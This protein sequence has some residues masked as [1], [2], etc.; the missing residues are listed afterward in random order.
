M[1]SAVGLLFTWLLC[2]PNGVVSEAI[3]P[4]VAAPGSSAIAAV[5]AAH[6]YS[7]KHRQSLL[8]AGQKRR[9]GA[10]VYYVAE[11]L[12][13]LK[14][15]TYHQQEAA[16][17]RYELEGERLQAA[18]AE[19]ETPVE[20]QLL[21]MTVQKT[22]ESKMEETSAFKSMY[23]MYYTMKEAF[24]G[25]STAPSCEYL[26][27]GEHA[28]CEVAGKTKM[29]SCKCRPCFTG[30]GFDCK[31]STCSPAKR[32]SAMPMYLGLKPDG[33][34][35]GMYD[36]AVAAFQQVRLVVAFRDQKQGGR[37]FLMLGTTGKEEIKWG[38]LQPF[39]G[40]V[41]AVE[42]Q[43]VALPTG[44]I[45]IHFRD[46]HED[47]AGFLVGGRVD[48]ADPFKAI[49][50]TPTAYARGQNEPS[51]LVTLASSRVVCLYAHPAAGKE[52]AFGGAL[53][54]QVSKGGTLSILGKYHFANHEV[55][56]VT[57]LALRPNSFVVAFRDPPTVD[58]HSTAP[59]RELSVV[60][61]A[62]E[63]NELFLDPHP[64][65][66]EPEKKGM[67]PRS[68]AL[69]SENLFSY[70]YQSLSERKS[71]MA[72]VRVDPDSHRMEVVG[73]PRDIGDG[74]TAFLHSISLPYLSL[75]P[76]T[77]TYFQH[78]RESSVA[79]SCRISPK[80]L[81]LQ[82][83]KVA[84]SDTQAGSAGAARLGDGRL[85]FVFSNK[86]KDPF[87]QMLGPPG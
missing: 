69:V 8:R 59:S 10:D 63:D 35:P 12:D 38:Q 72:I 4:A 70:S 14:V 76:H 48:E 30:D 22:E 20:R 55:S 50:L 1:A 24:G 62:M 81:I 52:P 26:S 60:W 41:V 61:M 13:K 77:F 15:A 54:L 45:V 56:Y 80:G 74:D 44:R 25:A 18:M 11:A 64:I 19:V 73:G 84:W 17:K 2:L 32:F 87:Y 66:I 68:L 79:K 78:P 27:C 51:Q 37:G 40:D 33:T 67:G 3:T 39:S 16:L 34:P 6:A 31:P 36:V 47:G 21:E 53:F 9:A 57:A 43:V 82:C 85:V 83:E 29:A 71:R 75:A 23:T 5:S 65:T 28:L 58:E 46:R 49:M 42:P 7:T 86:R